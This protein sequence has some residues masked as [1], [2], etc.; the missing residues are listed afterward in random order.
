MKVSA[1]ELAD[2][3]KAVVDRVIKRGEAADVE[4]H[5][6]TVVQIRRKVGVSKKEF[7]ERLRSVRFTDAEQRELKK[8]MEESAKVFGHAGRD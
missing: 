1:T 6:R 2:N 5:G 3:S 4:R 7:V 8:A